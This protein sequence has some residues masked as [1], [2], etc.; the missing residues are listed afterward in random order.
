MRLHL[1][2]RT[3]LVGNTDS[4]PR[5]DKGVGSQNDNASLPLPTP[6]SVLTAAHRETMGV[7]KLGNG[8]TP[9]NSPFDSGADVAV[10]KRHVVRIFSLTPPSRLASQHYQ[11]TDVPRSPWASGAESGEP[12]ARAGWLQP[13]A[14]GSYSNIAGRSA[15][16]CRANAGGSHTEC[17]SQ[18]RSRHTPYA[19]QPRPAAAC[20]AVTWG[21]EQR[22]STAPNARPQRRE[23]LC[24]IECEPAAA[25]RH[26]ECACSIGSRAKPAGA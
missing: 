20:A 1:R 11:G 6:F 2:P 8:W 24:E 13:A 15:G 16:P 10:L 9:A 3:R 19:V 26:M 17:G 18:P 25:G 4:L 7:R 22:P 21:A 23:G 5:T 14:A 12:V